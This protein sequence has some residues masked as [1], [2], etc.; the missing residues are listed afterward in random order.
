LGEVRRLRQPKYSEKRFPSTFKSAGI[1]PGTFE[2]RRLDET[3]GRLRVE[4][5]PG[6]DDYEVPMLPI[7][8]VVRWGRD[9]PETT[10]RLVY[11]FDDAR[12]VL[13]SVHRRL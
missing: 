10:L 4:E 12:V 7:A 5:L 3:I 6:P 1:R 13:I 2:A 8:E 9:V 11:D